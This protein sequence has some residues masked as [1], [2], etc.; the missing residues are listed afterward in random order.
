MKML[1]CLIYLDGRK[2]SFLISF[3]CVRR[4]LSIS[5]RGR[6]C[7][8]KVWSLRIGKIIPKEQVDGGKPHNP[9]VNDLYKPLLQK[10]LVTGSDFQILVRDGIPLQ[11]QMPRNG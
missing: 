3:S 4:S 8:R 2:A 1:N 5:A 6:N 7:R 11:I 9:Q 10:Q